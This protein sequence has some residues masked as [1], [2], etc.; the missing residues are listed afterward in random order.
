[1]TRPDLLVT[2]ELLYLTT[3]SS[4]DASWSSKK[5]QGGAV[6]D[7]YRQAEYNN[8]EARIRGC[9]PFLG[10]ALEPNKE[11]G[12]MSLKL[13]D[14]RFCRVRFCP[15]CQWRRQ[16]M[17]MARLRKALPKVITE[18]PKHRFIFL[19]LTVRNCLLTELRSTLTEMSSAWN[20]LIGR[21]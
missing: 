17:W 7:L 15:T 13:R 18:Y 11:T 16:M 4:R 6:A 19:T 12:E 20:R 5:A 8:L 9:S 14:A 10:F 2:D 21:K 1:M 3:F